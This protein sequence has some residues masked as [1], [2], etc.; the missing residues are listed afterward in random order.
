MTKYVDRE[1]VEAQLRAY[2]DNV[3]EHFSDSIKGLID[4]VV[5]DLIE[6]VKK[7]PAADVKENVPAKWIAAELDPS[8]V[9][10]SN[11][12]N[13]GYKTMAWRPDYAERIKYC[14]NCG[15]PIQESSLK[16]F[17]TNWLLNTCS[18]IIDGW[19]DKR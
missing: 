8:F 14:P 6:A 17:A 13:V 16:T 4:A 7:M 15:T 12:K 3:P 9:V 1:K 10:C 18:R 5:L 2:A 11:C 19:E